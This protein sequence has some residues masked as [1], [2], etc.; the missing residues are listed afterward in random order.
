MAQ[1][2]IEIS[3]LAEVERCGLLKVAPGQDQGDEL[4]RYGV[5]EVLERKAL[6]QCV[7]RDEGQTVT[8]FF[9]STAKG[10]EALSTLGLHCAEGHVLLD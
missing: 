3:L 4:S 9:A 10:R 5:L 2:P 6:V 1:D 8:Y 7:G